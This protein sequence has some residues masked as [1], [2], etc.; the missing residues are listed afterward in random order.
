MATKRTRKSTY[1]KK[2]STQQQ[3]LSIIVFLVVAA[4]VYYLTSNQPN[5]PT[6]T[7]GSEQNAEGFYY[8]QGSTQNDIYA[9]TDNLIGT[10]LMNELHTLVNE[11]LDL[12]SYDDARQAL[13]IIDRDLNDPT[14]LWGI[15]D[16]VMLNAT[17]DGGATWNREHVW[18]NSRLGMDR[19]DGYERNQAT[20]LHN[21]RASSVSINSSK[22]DRVFLDGTGIADIIDYGFYPGDDH[23]GD[24]A[25]IIFY[26]ATAYDFLDLIDNDLLLADETDHYTLEGARMGKLSVLLLWHKLDPVSDFE[27]ARNNR[28]EDIQGNRNPFIDRPE[29][30][31]L[32]WEN[33]TIGDLLKPTTTS[34]YM[35][36]M[37]YL[38]HR[39]D[40]FYDHLYA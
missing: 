25:R 9:S 4:V 20:D 32:I 26:M 28:I 7:Y 38:N 37:L 16:G 22:S 13:E 24:V 11:N 15:Y 29:F 6:P 23:R 8:Y 1:R 35:H 33:K 31:H 39:K 30:V 40:S 2:K 12:Q 3:I 5:E 21:L 34:S 36:I 17:W 27:V 10:A 14:K 19:V 18:P